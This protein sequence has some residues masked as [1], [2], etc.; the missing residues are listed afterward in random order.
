MVLEPMQITDPEPLQATLSG[1]TVPLAGNTE[2]RPSSTLSTSGRGRLGSC[3]GVRVAATGSYVPEQIVTNDDLAALGCDSDWI[4]KRTGISQR[5]RAAVEQASSDLAYEAI[6]ACLDLAKVKPPEVDLLICATMT[7]DFITPSTACILQQRLKCIAPAFDLNA[8]CAG[9]MYALVTGA[10]YVRGGMA[11]NALIVGSEVMSRTVD[12]RDIKTY[13][14][15]GDGAGAV[16]LQPDESKD[17]TPR[18]LLS[19]TLGSEGDSLALCV[20]GGGS[21]EPIC[22]EMLESGRQYLQ[23]DGRTVFI[24]AVRIVADSINDVLLAAGV[25]V[26][27]IDCVILH[28]ANIRIVDAAVSSFGIPKEKVFVNLDKYGNT[29]AASIPLALDDANRQGLIKRGDL[30]M[31]CGFGAGLAWGTALVRW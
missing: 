24:W 8:A 1:D 10:Q 14:L 11:R 27:S 2:L 13:P 28:Q 30:V 4:I 12:N 15:F 21:R 23:M 19:F 29:S 20:P 3:M 26:G 6:L 5:R 16:L 25:A 7:P 31:L 18:G 9:F 17:G 22:Q